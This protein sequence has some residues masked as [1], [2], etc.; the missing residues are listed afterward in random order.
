MGFLF[1]IHH[2]DNLSFF[3]NDLYFFHKSIKCTNNHLFDVS[4]YWYINF[5]I[6][7]SNPYSNLRFFLNQREIV[8]SGLFDEVIERLKD[9]IVKNIPIN[10]TILNTCCGEGSLLY[11]LYCLLPEYNYMGVDISR[12]AIKLASKKFKNIL[13]LVSNIENLNLKNDSINLILNFLAP[14]NYKEFSRVLRNDG[15]LFKIIPLE[16]NFV[17]L[18]DVLL[19]KSNVNYKGLNIVE[20]IFSKR[21]V[22]NDVVEFSYKKEISKHLRD[23]L[24]RIISSI[25]NTQEN[26]IEL[27][28]KEIS[29]HLKLL[30]GI[31]K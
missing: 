13:W 27:L 9:N 24:L 7:K 5:N 29:I 21:F 28:P 8:L 22:I 10:S 30:I 20:K 3:Y 19:Y 26:K 12:T 23:Y 31:K 18:R 25:F 2:I 16:N 6:K 14:A 15:Y 11:K 1:L 4:K 17:E